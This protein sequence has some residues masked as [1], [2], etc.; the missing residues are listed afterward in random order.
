VPPAHPIVPGISDGSDS[1]DEDEDEEYM[2]KLSA[3]RTP[4]LRAA[5]MGCPFHSLL[6]KRGN[7]GK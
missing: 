7:N 1:V 6:A 5:E 4:N 3:N 2:L